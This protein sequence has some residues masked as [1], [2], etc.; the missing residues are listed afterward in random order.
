VAFRDIHTPK[1]T[2]RPTFNT[3][4]FGAAIA[5]D[6][7]SFLQG[8]L[9]N[10]W[11]ERDDFQP[12]FCAEPD[13]PSLPHIRIPSQHAYGDDDEAKQSASIQIYTLSDNC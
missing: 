12:G 10:R 9:G 11:V 6:I 7:A 1:P 4:H 5:L 3:R 2:K 8:H 13:L